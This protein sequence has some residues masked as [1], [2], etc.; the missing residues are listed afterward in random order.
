MTDWNNYY[1][2]QAQRGYG[3]EPTFVTS[4]TWFRGHG[5]FSN[6]IGSIMKAGRPFLKKGGKYLARQ[7]IDTLANFGS[8][9][10]DGTSAKD[11]LKNS[12]VRA[13]DHLKDD[14]AH[15]LK[16]KLQYT[17]RNKRKKK[18]IKPRSKR[19]KRSNRG[20]YL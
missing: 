14:T 3:I 19:K 6:I 1:G 17:S 10:L 18:A 9:L 2:N 16:N 20:G 5:S 13:A 15:F 4:P 11:A 8:D 7:G 12:T